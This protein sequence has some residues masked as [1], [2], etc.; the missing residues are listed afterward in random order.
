MQAASKLQDL[1][2]ISVPRNKGHS[3]LS[4]LVYMQLL[5]GKV[6]NLPDFNGAVRRERKKKLKAK[7]AA[8]ADGAAAIRPSQGVDPPAAAQPA[9]QVYSVYH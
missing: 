6:S 7:Q 9:S 3:L 8:L 4:V 5:A 1:S 2:N